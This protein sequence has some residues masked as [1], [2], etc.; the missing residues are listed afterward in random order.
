[1]GSGEKNS[2]QAALEER[3]LSLSPVSIDTLWVNITSQ[4]NQSCA[5]CHIG[6]SPK[7]TERMDRATMDR[8]LEILAANESCGTLDITGGAPELH[9]DF[10]YFVERAGKL[11]KKVIV[12]H[13]LTIT[14]DGNPRTCEDM[15]W[16]PRYFAEHRIELIASLPSF[17]Q[18]ATDRVRGRGVFVKSLRSLRMLNGRGYGREE[19]GLVLNLMYNHDGPLSPDDRNA[20]EDEFRRELLSRYDIRFNRLLTVTNVPIKRFRLQLE[21]AGRYDEYMDRLIQ[22]FSESA[23]GDLACRSLVSVGFDGRLY[24]CDFN[25]ALEMQIGEAEPM[26][27]FNFDIDRLLHRT[28]RFGAHCFGCTAGGGSS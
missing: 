20:L 18:E 11:G 25:L 27:V 1:M 16:L 12:R 23:T 2:F 24:D 4:C 14:Q 28:I 13:N 9:P 6:A 7:R 19:T 21:E 26:T 5:H 10:K 22:C 17:E 3:G 8:C 15:S